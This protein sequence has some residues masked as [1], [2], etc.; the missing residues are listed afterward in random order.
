MLDVNAKKLEDMIFLAY[1]DVEEAC[2]YQ[3]L[4]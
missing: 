2:N 3:K 4:A 1:R